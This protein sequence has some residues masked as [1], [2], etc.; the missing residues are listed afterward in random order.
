MEN[1]AM[2]DAFALV[3]D[4]VEAIC[5]LAEKNWMRKYPYGIQGILRA[6]VPDSETQAEYILAGAQL[7]QAAQSRPQLSED[8]AVEVMAD[9]TAN[10]PEFPVELSGSYD[11]YAWFARKAYRALLAA[12]GGKFDSDINVVIKTKDERIKKLEDALREIQE[13]SRYTTFP[14][15]YRSPYIIAQEALNEQKGNDDD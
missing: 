10:S 5:S 12:Q 14:D 3:I 4:E 15:G 13:V 1:K 8:E 9:A 2:R 11:G 6:C 7:L